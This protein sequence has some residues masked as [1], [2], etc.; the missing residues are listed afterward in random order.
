M[1]LIILKL[2]EDACSIPSAELL[3]YDCDIPYFIMLAHMVVCV[4]F[5][6]YGV[7]LC[8]YVSPR[9]AVSCES[10]FWTIKK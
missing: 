2:P 8:Y 7:C 9:V 4:M 6:S 3:C 10:G 1:V 5:D